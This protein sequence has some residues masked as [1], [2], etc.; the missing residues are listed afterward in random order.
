[1]EKQKCLSE[2]WEEEKEENKF[3]AIFNFKK[4]I[5]ILYKDTHSVS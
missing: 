1:M 2:A 4:I 3:F 5:K